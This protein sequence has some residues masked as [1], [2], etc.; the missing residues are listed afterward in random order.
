M[1]NPTPFQKK[2][3]SAA[4]RELEKFGL[5]RENQDP[6]MSRIREYWKELGFKFESVSVPW[7]A[8]FVSWCV[9]QAGATAQQ[10]KFAA[11][12]SQFVKR[13]IS[14]ARA[15]TGLFHG[16]QLS[17]YAP[18]T[19]DILQ[20]NRAGNHFDFNFAATHSS[21]QSHSAVVVEVGVDNSGKYLRTVGGNE[22]DSVGLKEVR[23]DAQGRVKNP[24]GL[25][26]CAIE[27]LL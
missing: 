25:Y 2:L 7:S 19:G 12:H 15:S 11:A 6:L 14:D 5:F 17:D 4:G 26:I 20:N 13:A 3:A 10:F 9:K 21:Y 24:D 8:V 22:A 27:S 18:K 1:A 16:R 23:L